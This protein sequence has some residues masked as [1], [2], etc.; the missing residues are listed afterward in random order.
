MIIEKDD[1][2]HPFRIFTMHTHAYNYNNRSLS[3][4]L[5]LKPKI[6]K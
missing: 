4:L 2:F 6:I 5:I 3:N 1:I